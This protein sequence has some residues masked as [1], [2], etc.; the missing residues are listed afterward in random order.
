MTETSSMNSRKIAG[1]IRGAAG[2]KT[3]AGDFDHRHRGF[4]RNAAD[5]APDKLV[6]HKV[7]DNENAFGLGI[8]QN[9]S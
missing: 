9:L 6:Q 2:I 4:W 8:G 5:L 7:A 1:H 3:L